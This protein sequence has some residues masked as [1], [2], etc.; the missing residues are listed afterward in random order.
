MNPGLVILV[1]AYIVAMLGFF[2][3]NRAAAGD[4]GFF[5]LSRI[6][7]VMLF[8]SASGLVAGAWKQALDSREGNLAKERSARLVERLEDNNY[9][10]NQIRARLDELA[11]QENLT[12]RIAQDLKVIARDVGSVASLYA[13]LPVDVRRDRITKALRQGDVQTVVQVL[14]T[15]PDPAREEECSR[16]FESCLKRSR[17]DDAELV[18][19]ECQHLWDEETTND[20]LS[21]LQYERLKEHRKE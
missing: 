3:S 15:L 11:D 2:A 1:A 8:F 5:G 7:T 12:P 20:R 18:L 14:E 16:A 6:G 19:K 9:T 13:S 10:L 4:R 21:R 17:L